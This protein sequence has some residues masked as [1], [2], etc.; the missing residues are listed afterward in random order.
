VGK[1]R[2]IVAVVLLGYMLDAGCYLHLASHVRYG[3]LLGMCVMQRSH[4]ITCKEHSANVGRGRGS[5][6]RS[7]TLAGQIGD[8]NECRRPEYVA[9]S[10]ALSL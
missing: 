6:T 8:R 10:T 1:R 2:R 7:T 5:H 9:F 3:R 4:V